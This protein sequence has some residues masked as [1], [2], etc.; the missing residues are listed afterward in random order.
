VCTSFED[1]DGHG[2]GVKLEATCMLPSLS[3]ALLNWNNGLDYKYTAL[4]YR[5]MNSYIC[6]GRDRDPGQVYPDPT[7]KAPRVW[8]TPSA[9]DRAHTMKG[10]LEMSKMLLV[11]GAREIHAHVI[12]AAPYI[13]SP[14]ETPS[15][16]DPRFQ[17]WLAHVEKIG[18]A[19]PMGIY[20]CAHQMGSNRMAVDAKRG[21]VSPEGKVW[22][23][24]NLY[25]M[26]ASVFPSA[27]GGESWSSL[28]ICVWRSK[29]TCG[30]QPDG[31][32]PGHLRHELPALGCHDAG[33]GEQDDG[34]EIVDWLR[35][36]CVM[37]GCAGGACSDISFV[38]QNVE[39]LTLITSRAWGGIVT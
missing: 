21:V 28:L 22:E 34:A 13:V 37:R 9:F 11:A 35:R 17:A 30:S 8:Y 26:D 5:H 14:H 20:A 3:V 2:H 12:G 36:G 4:K 19:P 27:S 18:N 16:T 23:A 1:L 32:Q 31:H 33:G 6:I 7:T 15:V 25:V 38:V 10:L 29:L 39:Q 24:E